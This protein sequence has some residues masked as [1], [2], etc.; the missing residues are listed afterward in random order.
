MNQEAH[1]EFAGTIK[2]LKKKISESEGFL[3][4]MKSIPKYSE[5]LIARYEKAEGK[6][7]KLERERVNLAEEKKCEDAMREKFKYSA[8]LAKKKAPIQKQFFGNRQ[9]L[10][11]GISR[12]AIPI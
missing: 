2:E 1:E 9:L 4:E 5:A 8:L 3:S 6:E 7:E 11:L 12:E 10:C